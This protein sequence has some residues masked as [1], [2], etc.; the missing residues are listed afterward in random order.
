[1]TSVAAPRLRR[2]LISLALGLLAGF[3]AWTWH[4]QSDAPRDLG[5][6]W[7]AARALLDGVDPYQ[8]IGPGRAFEWVNGFYY[9]LPAAVALVPLTPLPQVWA[10]AV[11]VAVAGACFA[12][13]LMAHGYAPLLGFASASMIASVEMVQ[14]AP[15]LSAALAITP[16]AALYVAKPTIGFAL[17]VARPSWWAIGGGVVLLSLAFLAQPG[18]LASWKQTLTET[19]LSRATKIP[20]APPITMP[21][22]V[23]ALLALVRWRRPEA[24]LVAALA[25][26]PQTMYVYETVPLLLVPRTFRESY[27]MLGLTFAAAAGGL[28]AGHGLPLADRIDV[29]GRW[30]VWCLY[31][32]ATLMVLRRPNEGPMPARLERAIARW[33]TWLRGRS[34]ARA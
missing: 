8:V 20:Y 17:F 23:L 22:G 13:A 12:W 16:L 24:R 3:H 18:W 27:I 15:L 9:P 33:P 31:L 19:S 10:E 28:Y 5:Q 34:V 6:V 1:M 14:W 29:S 7:F 26:V 25:C 32:P 30:I 2:L 11:F 4:T 21:G